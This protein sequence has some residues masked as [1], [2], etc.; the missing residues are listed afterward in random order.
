MMMLLM[1][2]D[3]VTGCWYCCVY[4]QRWRVRVGS[5]PVDIVVT[6]LTSGST[7]HIQYSTVAVSKTISAI[8]VNTVIG[9][10]TQQMDN[11]ALNYNTV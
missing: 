7:G 4:C 8:A 9:L 5:T 2:I 3:H 10:Y 1:M 11:I 6:V